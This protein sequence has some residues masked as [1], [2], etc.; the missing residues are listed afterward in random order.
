MQPNYVDQSFM[1]ESKND[2]LARL[3][4]DVRGHGEAHVVVEEAGAG[5]VD[6]EELEVRLGTT[7]FDHDAD[8]ITI[9]DGRTIHRV[10]AESIVR[11]YLPVELGH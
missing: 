9:E 2:V 1:S 8:L 4:E 5:E 6:G 7:T 10:T 3:E 11:W